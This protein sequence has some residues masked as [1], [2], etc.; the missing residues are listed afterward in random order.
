MLYNKVI[1]IKIYSEYG[2]VGAFHLPFY[3]VVI[4]Y[5]PKVGPR[6]VPATRRTGHDHTAQ[7]PC[8]SPR[9]RIRH[10]IPPSPEAQAPSTT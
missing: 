10:L 4:H 7:G 1:Y 2:T 3:V 6:H 8:L 9:S 5:F